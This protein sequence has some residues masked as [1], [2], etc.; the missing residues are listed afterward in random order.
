MVVECEHSSRA[1][2]FGPAYLI[3]IGLIL[4]LGVNGFLLWLAVLL[5][6]MLVDPNQE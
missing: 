5:V 1:A 2:E 3:L 4:V 6:L